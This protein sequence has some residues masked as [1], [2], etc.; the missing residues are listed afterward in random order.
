MEVNSINKAIGKFYS[1]SV[2][3][4]L[5]SPIILCWFILKATQSTW[6]KQQ[7]GESSLNLYFCQMAIF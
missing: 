2:F 7:K 4:I 1:I 6:S 5:K 3:W